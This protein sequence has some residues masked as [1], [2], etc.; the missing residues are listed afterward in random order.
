MK[1]KIRKISCSCI[2]QTKN[3]LKKKRKFT[4]FARIASNYGINTKKLYRIK[5]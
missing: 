4:N 3:W 2:Y 1:S 5:S